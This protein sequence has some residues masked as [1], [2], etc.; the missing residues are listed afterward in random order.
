MKKSLTL[1]ELLV[2]VSILA[3]GIAYVLRSFMG[4]ITA[5]EITE[6]RVISLQILQEK[7]D[8]LEADTL[9]GTNLEVSSK[10]QDV[11]LGIRPA[12][13]RE[14]IEII[15][16]QTPKEPEEKELLFTLYKATLSL[17]WQESGREKSQHLVRIFAIPA[18]EEE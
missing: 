12:A 16:S 10:Q 7:M 5:I 14:Y 1:L 18:E 13:Y 9:L 8:Q 4:T 6:N 3:I 2:A 15:E 17:D 11:L